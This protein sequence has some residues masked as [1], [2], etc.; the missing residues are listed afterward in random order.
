VDTHNR[1]R[2]LCSASRVFDWMEMMLD[3]VNGFMIQPERDEVLFI[4]KQRPDFQKGKW[5]GIGGKIEDGETPLQAMV[6]EFREETGVATDPAIWQHTLSLEGHG[7]VVHF[8]R[9]FVSEFPCFQ[10]TTDEEVAVW[11]IDEVFRVVHEQM[12]SDGQP[13]QKFYQCPT[14]TNMRWILSLQQNMNVVF[15]LHIRYQESH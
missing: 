8:Y 12:Q 15:P 4:H 1:I 13:H 7:F 14:L 2:V 6:R 5:N 10:T 3:Y 11:R 9:T